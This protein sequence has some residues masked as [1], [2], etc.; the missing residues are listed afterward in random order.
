MWND[1]CLTYG[2]ID[3]FH[4]VFN[5]VAKQLEEDFPGIGPVYVCL[6]PS[7]DDYSQITI[8]TEDK[9]LYYD[10]IKAW[11]FVFSSISEL[12][13]YLEELYKGILEQI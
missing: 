4:L 2:V 7:L 8:I 10:Y 13:M 12:E 1:E 11:H 6:E 3:K 9:V 5:S